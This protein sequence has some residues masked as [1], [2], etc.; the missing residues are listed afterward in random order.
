[1]CTFIKQFPAI[2]QHLIVLLLSTFLHVKFLVALLT[3]L[4]VEVLVVLH[5]MVFLKTEC[6]VEQHRIYSMGSQP[7]PDPGPLSPLLIDLLAA[8]VQFHTIH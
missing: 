6:E 7:F 3:K 2:L 4:L 5:C 1:V 8:S